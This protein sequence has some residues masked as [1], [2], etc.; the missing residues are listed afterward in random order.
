MATAVVPDIAGVLGASATFDGSG[1]TASILSYAWTSVPGGSVIA[2]APIPLPDNSVSNTFDISMA[3]SEGLYHFEGDANDSSGN[4]RNGVVQN[5]TQV[6]GKVGSNAYAFVAASANNVISF[7]ATG[8]SF[9]SADAFSF[10]FWAKPSASQPG[11]N[12]IL[13]G[14][15]NFSTNGYAMFQNGGANSNLYSF[16]VGTGSGLSG[17]GVNFALTAGTWN[18]V[19][20]T[21]SANGSQTRIYVNN[22]VVTDVAF[23]TTIGAGGIPLT[24]G[25]FAAPNASLGFNGAIDEFCVWSRELDPYEVEAVYDSGSGS[26]AALGTTY[27]FTPDQVGTYTV[28]AEAREAASTNTVTADAVISVAPPPSTG[29]GNFTGAALGQRGFLGQDFLV[30]LTA[31]DPSEDLD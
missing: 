30:P 8:F 11:A 3:D 23:L 14:K 24:V 13:F 17:T 18:H 25:N 20:L 15:T 22:V 6:T 5:A 29:I 31:I 4:G 2:N 16:V 1:S 7:G 10:S 21:R 27:T 9:V 12:A 19:C 28:S 26:I